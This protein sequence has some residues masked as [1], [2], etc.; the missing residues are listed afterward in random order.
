MPVSLEKGLRLE[1]NTA[2]QNFVP[3]TSWRQVS[4]ILPSSSA[5]EKMH[6]IGNAPTLKLFGDERK[7]EKVSEYNY[8]ISNKKYEMTMTIDRDLIED[9]QTGQIIAKARNMGTQYERELDYTVLTHLRYGTSNVCYDG[10]YFFDT[11]HSEGLSGTQAN[12]YY[13]QSYI[14]GASSL[15]YAERLLS[16]FKDD[17]GRVTGGRLTHVFTKRGSH[18]ARI[19]A[20]L[21]NSQYSIETS[22]GKDNFF[23]GRFKNVELDYGLTYGEWI[24]VDGSKGLLPVAVTNRV[25]LENPEFMALENDSSNGFW[26]DEFAY[27]LRVRFGLGYY[28]WRTA[29]L[30]RVI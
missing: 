29:V 4:S 9:D 5:T 22:L 11:D 20:E 12:L 28:D 3:Q 24:A 15:Q 13:G 1:F 7:P 18:E 30:F 27:G 6:M 21:A 26:R 19:F 10:Q 8:V 23:K 17:K 25:G 14:A 16:E 2:R